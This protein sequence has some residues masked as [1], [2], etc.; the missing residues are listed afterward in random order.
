MG[1]LLIVFLILVVALGLSFL[2]H[3]LWW[4]VIVI[5]VLWILGLVIRPARRRNRT[6]DQRENERWYHW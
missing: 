4:I 1:P 5:F 6:D 2:I 3:A